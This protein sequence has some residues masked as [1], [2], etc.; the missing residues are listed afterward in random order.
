LDCEAGVSPQT[1]KQQDEL[2]LI[3]SECQGQSK[4]AFVQKKRQQFGD[5]TDQEQELKDV[6][7]LRIS[8]ESADAAGT[9]TRR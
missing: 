6:S 3:E 1:A 8:R 9:M 4:D 5:R 2:V 7:D